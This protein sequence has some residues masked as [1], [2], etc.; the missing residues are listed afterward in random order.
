MT[1]GRHMKHALAYSTSDATA[2][3]A[4]TMTARVLHWTTAF[5]V[6]STIPLGIVAANDW[7]G[8]MQDAIYDL[9]RSVGAAIIPLVFLRLVYR[10]IRPPLP[11]SD[12]IPKVQ[13]FAAYA[14]HWGLYILLIAQP[15]TGWIATSAY[16]ASVLVFGWFELPP[17]W[18]ENRA[19]SE[20]LFSIH[21]LWVSRSRALWR[22]MPAPR[23]IIIS[24]AK[25]PSSCASSPGDNLPEEGE[26]RC[27]GI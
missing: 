23:S 27:W 19:F 17:I 3:P 21:S 2:G 6:L 5:L 7:G 15:L 25:T 13:R 26:R 14:T 11:L 1:A 24:C 20:E 10:W 8:S 4:Y 22:R 18:P 16:R 9:H 12:D